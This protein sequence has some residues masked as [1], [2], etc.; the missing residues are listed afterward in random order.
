VAFYLI[1]S[2]PGIADPKAKQSLQKFIHTDSGLPE[3][4]MCKLQEGVSKGHPFH[5]L[6]LCSFLLLLQKKWT[7]EK[8]SG[9]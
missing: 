6:G 2:P 8:E 5:L 7:K 1:A 4:G 3:E 9:N